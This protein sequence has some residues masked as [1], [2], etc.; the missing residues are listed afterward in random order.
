MPSSRSARSSGSL[1]GTVTFSRVT[2]VSV[3]VPGSARAEVCEAACAVGV[4]RL[5]GG[6]LLDEMPGT[7]PAVFVAGQLSAVSGRMEVGESEAVSPELLVALR[8][9]EIPAMPIVQNKQIPIKRTSATVP[10]MIQD[11]FFIHFTY[12][13]NLHY[14]Y[15]IPLTDGGGQDGLVGYG[16]RRYTSV[17]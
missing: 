5:T 10:D 17:T 2:N 11:W 3:I 13:S 16:V 8:Y 1:I 14:T 12:K 7:E 9:S 6:V 4:E 15:L